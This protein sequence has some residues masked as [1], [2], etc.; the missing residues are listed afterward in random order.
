M[1]RRRLQLYNVLPHQLQTE[2]VLLLLNQKIN[3][4]SP[5]KSAVGFNYYHARL[6]HRHC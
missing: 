1:M 4:I 6:S 5:E 3:W 2:I